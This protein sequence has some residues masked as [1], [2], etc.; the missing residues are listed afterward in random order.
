MPIQYQPA[1]GPSDVGAE[2]A[3]RTTLDEDQRFSLADLLD[4]LRDVY[5]DLP[6]EVQTAYRNAVNHLV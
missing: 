6:V 3:A 4:V 2:L 1:P 5:P